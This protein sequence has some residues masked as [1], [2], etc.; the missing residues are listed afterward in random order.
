MTDWLTLLERKAQEFEALEYRDDPDGLLGSP[1]TYFR[2]ASEACRIALS[3]WKHG[4]EPLQWEA[5]L[6]ERFCAIF[7][8]HIGNRTEMLRMTIAGLLRSELNTQAALEIADLIESGES[9]G[10]D[11][12]RM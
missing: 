2:D 3:S 11:E 8:S 4:M 6:I 1:T 10:W 12:V 9:E 5:D 7:L